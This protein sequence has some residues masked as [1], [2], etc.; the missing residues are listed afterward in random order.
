MIK[1]DIW[2]IQIKWAGKVST[3]ARHLASVWLL[4]SSDLL[5]HVF[6]IHDRYLRLSEYRY[7]WTSVVIWLCRASLKDSGGKADLQ[8]IKNHKH[9]RPR[10]IK[11][12][13]ECTES[14]SVTGAMNWWSGALNIN[15]HSTRSSTVFCLLNFSLLFFFNEGCNFAW[16][17]CLVYVWG[18][19][20]VALTKAKPVWIA[21]LRQKQILF[22]FTTL[23]NVSRVPHMWW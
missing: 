4:P 5:L 22:N 2:R 1:C 16:W 17:L 10:K 14:L 23:H 6:W 12:D 8:S 15:L 7:M 18:D 9:R 21:R 19:F 13:V 3:S 11:S 20:A